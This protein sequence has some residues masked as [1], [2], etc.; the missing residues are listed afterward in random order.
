MQVLIGVK[1]MYKTSSVVQKDTC[2][3]ITCL[4]YY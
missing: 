2:N 1:F 3:K 4:K